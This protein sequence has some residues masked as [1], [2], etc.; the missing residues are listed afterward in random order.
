M[1]TRM[2]GRL[3]YFGVGVLAGVGAG[4]GYWRVYK[5][6]ELSESL[7]SRHKNTEISLEQRVFKSD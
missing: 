2:Q 3:A 4:A 7:E 6:L 5:H 1:G